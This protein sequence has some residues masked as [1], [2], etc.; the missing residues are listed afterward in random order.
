VPVLRF[1]EK[2]SLWR[3]P[4]LDWLFALGI[5][6]AVQA[7]FVLVR[8]VLVRRLGRVAAR[9]ATEWDDFVVDLARRTRSLL[10]ALPALFLGSLHLEL[11]REATGLLKGAAAL[12]VLVQVGLWG[13]LAI[14]F[15]VGRA[16]AKRLAENAGT[17]TLL[18][19]A[20][21]AG[22]AAL[23]TLL[24]VLALD[25]FGVNVTALVAGLGIGGVA[26]ALALQNILGDLLASLSIVLDKPFVVGDAITVGD[27]SGKV[28]HIGLKTTRLRSLSGEEVVLPNG[29]LLKS[30]IHNWRR[31]SE[32]RMV[33]SFGVVYDTPLDKLRAMPEAV[34]AV[35]EGVEG[36]RFDRVHLV[37][38]GSSS[39]DFD[40]AYWVQSPEIAASLDGQQ[41]VL[42]GVLAALAE[43][44]VR[45]AY[46][47]QTV[48]V[49]GQLQPSP[50]VNPG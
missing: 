16:R 5:A 42:L 22:Q 18:G 37:R 13:S 34:R 45:L 50:A 24:L 35:I 32:R 2:T 19:V 10:V 40:A 4:L 46:P 43:R 39:I 6:V 27:F 9:T 3:D 48:I 44:G 21:F 1:L 7:A 8:R 49:S 15:W 14:D 12:A 41:Q 17:A 38:L 36:V 30:R 23:W 28:E 31:M 47:T 25:N 20:R 11:P 33:L 26:I 29:E